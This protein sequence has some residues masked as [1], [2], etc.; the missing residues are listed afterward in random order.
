MNDQVLTIEQMRHLKELGVDTSKGSMYWHKITNT[1]TNKVENDWYI[2]I[3]PTVDLP[4]LTLIS[5]KLE[6]IQTFTFQD[7]FDLL[8]KNITSKDNNKVCLE[9]VFPNNNKWEIFYGLIK[10]F[11]DEKL[12]NAAYK[13]LVW[14][15]ENDYININKE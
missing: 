3:N 13:M 7:I 10:S 5:R 14:C 15:A 11:F 8:P 4:Q 6:T 9:I 1:T 12:I 2:D